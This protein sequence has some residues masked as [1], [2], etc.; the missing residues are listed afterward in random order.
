MVTILNNNME[1]YRVPPK[2]TIK[3]N[4]TDSPC[5]PN[6]TKFTDTLIPYLSSSRSKIIPKYPDLV[7]WFLVGRQ[8]SKQ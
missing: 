7:E 6:L 1:V 4:K 3:L 5:D 2:T 8:F